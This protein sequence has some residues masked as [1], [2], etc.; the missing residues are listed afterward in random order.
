MCFVYIIV[1]V[2]EEEVPLYR[3]MRVGDSW[4]RGCRQSRYPQCEAN[5]RWVHGISG[6]HKFDHRRRDS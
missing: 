4:N 2:V 5:L 1:S 6:V 3:S